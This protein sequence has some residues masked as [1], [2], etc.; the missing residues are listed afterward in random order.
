VGEQQTVRLSDGTRLTLNTDSRVVIRFSAGQRRVA[1]LKGEAMFEVAKNPHR[2]FIV[3]ASGEEVRALGT[4]FLVRKDAA[5]VK[6]TLVEGK[7]SVT[8]PGK[9]ERR[10]VAVLAP[11]QRLTL[12]DQAAAA[13]IDRPKL[14]AVTA[15]RRGQVMFDDVS[16]REAA[17]ELNRY[18]GRRILVGDPSLDGLKISGVFSTSDPEAFAAAASQLLGLSVR[19]D[20]HGMIL[21]RSAARS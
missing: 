4:V 6:V 21:E 16:L 10:L 8:A 20:A 18:G 17:A 1:L 15:W 14:D 7:V 11:G 2:P 19:S 9:S 12:R 13:A 3:L 5:D